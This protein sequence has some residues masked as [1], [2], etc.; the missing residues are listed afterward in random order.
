MGLLVLASVLSVLA[1]LWVRRDDVARLVGL[2]PI[3]APIG[4]EWRMERRVTFGSEKFFVQLFDQTKDE[5]VWE[6]SFYSDIYH[7]KMDRRSQIRALQRKAISAVF[8]N[9][10]PVEL[11]RW[12]RGER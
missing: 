11:V 12:A 5:V 4:F 9:G 8:G 3:R 1:L 2:G 10:V 6:G 7:L